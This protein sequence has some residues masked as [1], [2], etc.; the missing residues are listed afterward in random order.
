MYRIIIKC[1][2]IC[3][4]F[5]M[6]PKSRVDNVFTR[7]TSDQVIGMFNVLDD[8][9][10]QK[11][12]VSSG[13]D[14]IMYSDMSVNLKGGKRL[15]EKKGDELTFY[16][17]WTPLANDNIMLRANKPN[18]NDNVG[19]SYRKIPL[20]FIFITPF[21]RTLYI[22]R[23]IHNPSIEIKIDVRLMKE[24]LSILAQDSNTTLN[25][26]PLKSYDNGRWYFE[27]SN[28]YNLTST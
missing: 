27:M 14:E 23:I 11:C 16:L 8:Y 12:K 10:E 25:I 18:R 21:N 2:L 20:Y 7:H 9:S 3:V 28:L 19:V 13:I 4:S 17:G 6:V 26:K 24:H 1:L 22:E 5:A 15:A